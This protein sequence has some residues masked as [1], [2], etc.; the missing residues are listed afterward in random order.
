MGAARR[1]EHYEMAA[2]VSARGL[3]GAVDEESVTDLL[4][5]TL[6]EEVDADKRLCSL[7]EPLLEAAK[8]LTNDPS[9]GVAKGNPPKLGKKK[10]K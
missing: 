6:D 7:A 1:V 5:M 10:Q 8:V 2:Y 4:Q 3:A 9:N